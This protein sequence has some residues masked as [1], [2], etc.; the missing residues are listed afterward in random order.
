MTPRS[1]PRSRQPLRSKAM[2]AIDVV[3]V[4]AFVLSIPVLIMAIKAWRRY[5]VCQPVFL[6]VIL[7]MLSTAVY[8]GA[9][10]YQ[11]AFVPGFSIGVAP[12]MTDWGGL[13]R[14]QDVATWFVISI[15]T[16]RI[17]GHNGH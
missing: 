3:R 17:W 4:L 2:S 6:L 14:L 12:W 10:L 7:L 16:W 1:I 5:R 9:Y 15:L 13:V 8:Y 11:L